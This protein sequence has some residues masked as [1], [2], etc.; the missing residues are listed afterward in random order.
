MNLNA[1]SVGKN[2]PE[3]VKVVIEIAKTSKNE[4]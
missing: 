3:I 4:K 2:P 1:L